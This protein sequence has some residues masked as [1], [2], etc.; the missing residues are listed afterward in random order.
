MRLSARGVLWCCAGLFMLG[1]CAA[2]PPETMEISN[3]TELKQAESKLTQFLN[4]SCVTAIDCD[5][6]FSWQAYGQGKTFSATMQAMQP[7]SLRF[8]IIDPLGRPLIL[9]GAHGNHFTLTDNKKSIGYTGTMDLDVV[10]KFLPE[11]IPQEDI[12][13]WLSGQVNSKNMQT[14]SSRVDTKENLSWYEVMYTSGSSKDMKQMLALNEKNQLVR[15]IVFDK[16]DDMQFEAKYSE[17][18]KTPRACSWPSRIE[19]SGDALQADLTLVFSEIV[20][21]NPIDKKRFQ[22]SIPPHFEVRKVVNE[23]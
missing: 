1:G 8:A 14:I 21:F 19:F 16:D 13:Y 9:L 7:S 15:H 18:V 10:K 17:Y 22:V 12:F 3:S 11:F 6:Q 20:N 2:K 4:Q 23:R 5:V